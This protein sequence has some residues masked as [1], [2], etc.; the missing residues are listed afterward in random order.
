MPFGIIWWQ[1]ILF[2]LLG[3]WLGQRFRHLHP[4]KSVANGGNGPSY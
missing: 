4:V 3:A 1:A 2:F